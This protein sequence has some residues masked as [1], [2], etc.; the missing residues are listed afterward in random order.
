[1]PPN[2]LRL[3]VVFGA[4][5]GVRIKPRLRKSRRQEIEDKILVFGQILQCYRR[6]LKSGVS[7]DTKA[8]VAHNALEC[9]GR[10][11]SGTLIE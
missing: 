5:N 8:F 10:Q 3:K 9:L 6:T 11:R 4:V 2:D 1:M 7:T